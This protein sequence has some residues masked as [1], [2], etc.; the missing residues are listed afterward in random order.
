ME[1]QYVY[2][3]KRSEFGRQCFFGD[4]GPKNI[5]NFP[6]NRS[7]MD[8]YILRD[9]VHVGVQCSKTFAEHEV[10]LSIIV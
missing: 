8:E 5:D 9:P 4:D 3:K 2:T 7:L 6:P 10:G 1:N